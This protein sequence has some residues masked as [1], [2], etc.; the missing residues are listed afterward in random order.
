MGYV[1]LCD[2]A[3]L[4]LIS[5]VHPAHDIATLSYCHFYRCV[6]TTSIFKR[7][8]CYDNFIPKNS[9]TCKSG[10]KKGNQR[11]GKGAWLRTN[12]K[13]IR[14]IIY[15]IYLTLTQPEYEWKIG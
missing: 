3:L 4:C 11:K 7:Q 2:Y 12:E 10:N 1:R 6:P 9:K 5:T 8:N 15:V 14:N 13:K